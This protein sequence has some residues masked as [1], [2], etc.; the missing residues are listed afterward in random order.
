MPPPPPPIALAF[1]TPAFAGIPSAAAAPVNGFI[2]PP[3]PE[4]KLT[5]EI[6]WRWPHLWLYGLF[7]WG[8]P[9]V[10][11]LAFPTSGSFSGFLN[12]QL[13]I[14]FV[15]YLLAGVV[16]YVLVSTRQKGDWSTLGVSFS[17]LSYEEFL[18]GGGFGLLLIACWIPIGLLMSGG[19]FE[20]DTLTQMLL[21]GTSGAGLLLSAVIVIVG[22]PIIEEIYYR[23]M[24]YE[25][26]ARRSRWLAIIGTSLL[27]VSAH[28]ALIIPPLLMLAFGLGWKRQT[29]G[30]WYTIGAH[31]AWNLVVTIMAAYV[32]LGPAASFTSTDNAFSVHYPADWQRTEEMEISFPGMSLDLV[33]TG[34]NASMIAVARVD[35]PA[36]AGIT[37][38]RAIKRTLTFFGQ[39]DFSTAQLVPSEPVKVSSTVGGG[40][41]A[42]ELRNQVS[43]PISGLAGESRQIAVMPSGWKKVIVFQLVCPTV[44]CGE[45]TPDFEQLMS[46]AILAPTG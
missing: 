32:L 18:R 8:I 41:S 34:P 4:V 46:S 20:F 9:T 23:G 42:Y 38:D 7:A 11:G 16:A 15:C 45:A 39:A 37:P 26:L 31:A 2:P 28:G 10:Y 25:K 24:L 6:K 36:R 33:L 35:V 1:G 30:L 44:S 13:A 17:N 40:T 5:S 19:E 27:F 14:Q 12:L 3:F 29:H 43:D 22:A 21:G